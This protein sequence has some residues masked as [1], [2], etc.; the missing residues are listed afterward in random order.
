MHYMKYTDL[1]KFS[2]AATG[3]LCAQGGGHPREIM[4]IIT[5]ER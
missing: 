2:S 3:R 5:Q 4:I 1:F